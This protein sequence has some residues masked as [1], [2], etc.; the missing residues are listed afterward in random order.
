MEKP[1]RVIEVRNRW[2]VEHTSKG[3]SVHYQT[4]TFKRDAEYAAK[5]IN[6]PE[7]DTE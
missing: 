7:G 5:L 4:F 2:A 3:G 1:A 6:T